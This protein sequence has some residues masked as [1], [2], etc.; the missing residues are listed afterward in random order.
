MVFG[1]KSLLSGSND[2]SLEGFPVNLL[3]DNPYVNVGDKGHLSF[4]PL[5]GSTVMIT[6][7]TSANIKP[8]IDTKGSALVSDDYLTYKFSQA[9]KTSELRKV[10]CCNQLAN[11]LIIKSI[12][13]IGAYVHWLVGQ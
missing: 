7:L 6:G 5:E 4:V 13:L 11:I 12:A 8:E 1:Q 3:K 9:T 10:R 2:P